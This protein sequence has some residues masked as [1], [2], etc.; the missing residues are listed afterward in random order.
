[1]NWAPRFDPAN[2]G[3]VERHNQTDEVFVLTKGRSL[4]FI[5]AEGAV[6]AVDMQPGV[7]YNVTAGTWHGTLG[8][9][10]A[11]WL[12]VESADTNDKNSDYRQ[13]DEGELAALRGQ[14]PGW[15][16]S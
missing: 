15:L 16:K 4:L 2:V 8:T 3:Q 6:K 14:Y 11:S 10:D 7:I 1:M 12:I 13:L 5:E 9:R